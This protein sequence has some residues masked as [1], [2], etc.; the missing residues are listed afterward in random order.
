[1]EDNFIVTRIFLM[2]VLKP[3]KYCSVNLNIAR[4]SNAV[5]FYFYIA[6]IRSAIGIQSTD[7]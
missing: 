4:V 7:I 5:N 3:F 1:M 2:L 6:E